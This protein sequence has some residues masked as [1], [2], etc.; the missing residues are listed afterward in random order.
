MKGGDELDY[1]IWEFEQL[2]KLHPEKNLTLMH[3]YNGGQKSFLKKTTPIFVDSYVPEIDTE[4]QYHGCYFHGHC[5]MRGKMNEEHR[6]DGDHRTK[7]IRQFL[8]DD[9]HHLIEKY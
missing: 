1:V 9:G 6:L 5:C 2:Q 4:I 7:E 3:S 8:N